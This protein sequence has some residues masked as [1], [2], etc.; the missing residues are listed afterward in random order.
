MALLSSDELIA[1][2]KK[3]FG[4]AIGPKW[5]VR[6]PGRV[7]LIGEHTDYNH[8]WVLPMAIDRNIAI[9]CSRND[10]AEVRLLSLAYGKAGSFA[11]R[12]LRKNEKAPWINYPQGGACVM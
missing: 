3:A 10:S 9:A 11:L 12:R 4:S 1:E 6:A 7:N 5:I 2:F 8:G